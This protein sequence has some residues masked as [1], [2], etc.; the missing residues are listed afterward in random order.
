MPE[1]LPGSRDS[2]S[3]S[4][5]SAGPHRRSW[6]AAIAK[7][8]KG[9]DYEKKLVWRTEEG[10]R[11][12]AV[13]PPANQAGLEAQTRTSPGQL[14]VC[15]RQRQ[16]MGDRAGRRARRRQ[17]HSRRP[18]ARSRRPRHPGTRLRAGGGRGAAG[19]AGG[20]RC[21]WMTAAPLDRI[22]FRG[23]P[24]LFPGDRQA[25][26]RAA[27]L[28]AG[29]GGVR[30]GGPRMRAGPHAPARAHTRGQQERLRPLYQPA[31]RDHRSAGGGGWR[32]RP[33]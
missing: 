17:C 10:H 31:A 18:A 3:G 4:G 20:A 5:F 26:R 30:A 12:A 9:A 25:A 1:D 2:E 13:L 32:L 27:V 33:A 6:E 22:R 19:R 24:D 21:R 8:L 11:R 29:G 14:P 16:A 28:G 23:R 15:A 7:D